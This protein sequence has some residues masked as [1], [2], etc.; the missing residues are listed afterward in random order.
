[1]IRGPSQ[2]TTVLVSRAGASSHSQ[3]EAWGSWDHRPIL[4]SGASGCSFQPPQLHPQPLKRDFLKSQGK[5]DV[6]RSLKQV[7]AQ[8][9]MRCRRLFSLH[10]MERRVH[11]K[12]ERLGRCHLGEGKQHVVSWESK[13]R[14]CHV[15]SGDLRGIIKRLTEHLSYSHPLPP[16][17]LLMIN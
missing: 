13:C 6:L 12:W 17:L 5:T 8:K 1:M 10:L 16:F 3:R 7:G 15:W 11:I 4:P 9:G 2:T 14:I